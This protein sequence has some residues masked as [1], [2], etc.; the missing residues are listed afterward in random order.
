MGR[1]GRGACRLA[2][3]L[4]LPYRWLAASWRYRAVSLAD[5]S[6]GDPRHYPFPPEILAVSER[7]VLA[8][9]GLA[10]AARLLV[11][12]APGRDGDW[13]ADLLGRAGLVVVRGALRRGG[14][15]ALRELRAHLATDPAP[16]VLAVDGP[17]GPVGQAQGGAALLARW[18]GRAILPLAV[19]ARPALRI[20]GTW[21]HMELPL[22]GARVVIAQGPRR[23]V[24]ADAPAS[25]LAA[26]TVALSADLG[27]AREG[28]M[29]AVARG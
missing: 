29:A 6:V 26:H 12:V 22:P 20:P 23:S 27:R 10:G 8:L 28:A 9:G 17:L 5:A 24:A 18:S 4:F 11:L 21:A 3:A 13:A 1:R 2:R 16:L 7:D 14:E 19:A 25:T 15:R